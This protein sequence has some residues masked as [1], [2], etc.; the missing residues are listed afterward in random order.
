M[1]ITIVGAGAIGGTL[2]A[3]LARAGVPVRL[4]DTDS[5]HVA[6]MNERGLTIRGFAEAFTVPVHALTPERLEGPV[7]TVL[8]A[9]K[10]QHTA[11]AVRV[12]QP[13]LTA[14]SVVVSVQN[15]L[16]ERVIADIIGPERTLG[17][18]VM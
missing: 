13:H 5:S 14:D 8:L 18:F 12:L 16:C 11:E 3:Y 17:C 4:V 2:G 1:N 10:A 15:G 7:E 6:A 9:V